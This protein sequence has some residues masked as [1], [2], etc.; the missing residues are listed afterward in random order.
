MA[1]TS[2][3]I[4]LYGDYSHWIIPVIASVS[5]GLSLELFDVT[6]DLHQIPLVF[7]SMSTS[8]AAIFALV[9]AI[10]TISVQMSKR[11][12]A[13]DLFFTYSTMIL[14]L[15]FSVTIILPLLMLEIGYYFPKLMI[16]LFTFC[17]FSLHPFLKD[18]SSKLKFE[19][20]LQNLKEEI[21]VAIDL[22]HDASAANKIR[23]FGL[24]GLITIKE[25]KSDRLNIVIKSISDISWIVIEEIEKIHILNEKKGTEVKSFELQKTYDAI[26]EELLSLISTTSE[27]KEN[28]NV[29]EDLLNNYGFYIVQ[30][31]HSYGIRKQQE[32]LKNVGIKFIE[33]KIDNESIN[34]IYRFL[35]YI[36]EDDFDFGT[37]SKNSIVYL[38]ELGSKSYEEN[39]KYSL[40]SSILYLWYSGAHIQNRFSKI[41]TE[42]HTNHKLFKT[43]EY[44]NDIRE[45]TIE[46]LHLMEKLV[47]KIEFENFYINATNCDLLPGLLNDLKSFR[48]LYDVY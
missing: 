42:S 33:N 5:I 10:I 16:S 15:I 29:L 8:L 44:I 19:I 46:Q 35:F 22:N 47:G 20:G 11:Y 34:K 37:I 26:G 40:K 38:N 24:L 27:K 18:I 25:N 7:S 17:I 14:M 4:N 21:A 36:L 12:T 30:H 31:N 6:F 32:L 28:S 3:I 23:D 45:T 48:T 13:M 9:F 39:L 43:L 2:K 41:Q 1:L